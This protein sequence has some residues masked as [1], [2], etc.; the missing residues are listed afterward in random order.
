M[1]YVTH[2]IM[3]PTGSIMSCCSN[4]VFKKYQ[5]GKCYPLKTVVVRVSPAGRDKYNIISPEML[6]LPYMLYSQ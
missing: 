1:L 5:H 2:Q 6:E 3:H 4:D